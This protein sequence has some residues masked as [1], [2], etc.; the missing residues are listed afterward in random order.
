MM[1]DQVGFVGLGIMGGPMSQNMS[2]KFP[3]L[4][5]DV[6]PAR[7]AAVS[8]I[9]KAGSAAE[10][11]TGC[12]VIF[13]S[14]PSAAVVE[15][16]VL[17]S[18]GLA[19]LMRRGSL[20]VDL[21]TSLPSVSR[22]IAERLA[23]KGVE[24]ADAP[25]SGGEGGARSATLAVMVGASPETFQRARP[26]LSAAGATVVRVGGVGAGGIAELVNNMIVASTFAVIAEGMAL[27]TAN[28]LDVMALYDAIREGWAGS[29]VLD[30]SAPAIA[31]RQYVPGGTV[32][33]LQKDLSYARM[34]ASD[35]LCPIPM[36]A[37][38]HEVFVAGQAAG[39]GKNAQPAIYELWKRSGG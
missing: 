33:M 1:A 4:G 35:S 26:Y 23:A 34:L 37:A 29:K 21:S 12:P 20:L 19:D 6:Q 31:A 17:G 15:D 3:V 36:T 16:V 5:F 24:F 25:V 14:L 27:A 28:G 39:F 13:L 10:I 30:V 11:A 7:L 38:A 9:S 18:G 8:G 22:R 2:K 32:D